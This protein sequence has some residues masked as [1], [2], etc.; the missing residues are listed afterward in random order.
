MTMTNDGHF[1]HV[2]TTV[3]GSNSIREEPTMLQ[4]IF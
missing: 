1:K 3:K 2:T 4:E